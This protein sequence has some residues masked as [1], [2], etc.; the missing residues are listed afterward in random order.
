[1]KWV[2]LFSLY[3]WENGNLESLLF[4]PDEKTGVKEGQ[5][6]YDL[7]PDNSAL[8]HSDPDLDFSESSLLTNLA[9]MEV[10]KCNYVHMCTHIYTHTPTHIYSWMN[11]GMQIKLLMEIHGN[12]STQISLAFLCYHIFWMEHALFLVIKK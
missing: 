5:K 12:L 2:L 4:F 3:K 8:T 6:G 9:I 7:S 10:S 11:G 1:M